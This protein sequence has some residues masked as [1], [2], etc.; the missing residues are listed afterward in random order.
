M[1]PAQIFLYQE[2]VQTLFDQPN[3]S[4]VAV[5]EIAGMA[6]S[7]DDDDVFHV[8]L[9]KP[10]SYFSGVPRRAAV[11]VVRNGGDTH[12]RETILREWQLS[13]RLDVG[14]MLWIGDSVVGGEAFVLTGPRRGRAT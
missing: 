11:A 4:E 2:H 3:N 10:E 1:D 12:V 14:V 9:S 13:N 6:M 7:L 5:Q 8:Y